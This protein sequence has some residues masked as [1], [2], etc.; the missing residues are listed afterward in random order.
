MLDQLNLELPVVFGQKLSGVLRPTTRHKHE[1]TD[2]N[3]LSNWIHFRQPNKTWQ[4]AR[5]LNQTSRDLGM[6]DNNDHVVLFTSN[7]YVK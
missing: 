1:L 5:S 4:R 2:H 3:L 6:F 7:K